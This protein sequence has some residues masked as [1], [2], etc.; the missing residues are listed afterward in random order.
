M[1]II[2]LLTVIKIKESKETV[3]EI[4]AARRLLSEN[5]LILTLIERVK[6]ALERSSE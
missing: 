6:I 2:K 4:I 3:K 5:I 1:D